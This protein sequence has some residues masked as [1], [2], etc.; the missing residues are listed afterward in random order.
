MRLFAESG[1]AAV[2]VRD[3][4]KA[5]DVSSSLVIHHYRSKDSL[6]TAVDE[7]ATAALLE[8]FGGLADA[9][10]LDAAASSLAAQFAANLDAEPVLPSYIRRMLIDGGPSGDALFRALYDGTLQTL[11]GLRKAGAIRKAKD[12]R[13][14]A[15]FLMVNDLAVII[16]RDQIAGVLGVDPLSTEGVK[17]WTKTVMEFYGPGMFTPEA[18]A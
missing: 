11:D 15:A 13:A 7:W 14:R 5:A 10:A 18:G 1:V 9:G 8:V 4:A 17:R 2:S 16:M 6:K 12:E 3:I